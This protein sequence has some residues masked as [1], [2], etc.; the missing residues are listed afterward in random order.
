MS[1]RRY[2]TTWTSEDAINYRLYIIPSNANYAGGSTDVTLPSDFLLR[3]MTLDTELGELPSGMMSQVLKM[4]FNIASLEG[5]AD[6]N[7][8]RIQLLKGST[9]KKFPLTVTGTDLIGNADSWYVCSM[10]LGAKGDF[11]SYM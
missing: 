10:Y 1:N 11:F 6:L 7:N 8:L 3:D 9:T 2:V 4:S 5:T